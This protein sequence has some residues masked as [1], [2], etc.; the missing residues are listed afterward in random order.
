MN[1][2]ATSHVYACVPSKFIQKP[3]SFLT[4]NLIAVRSESCRTLFYILFSILVD[5]SY[6]DRLPLNVGTVYF[7]PL[8]MV[9]YGFILDTF[10]TKAPFTFVRLVLRLQSHM[11]SRSP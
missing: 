6:S 1:E 11:T 5:D 2:E 7:F 10:V 8:T 3:C 9:G 4:E